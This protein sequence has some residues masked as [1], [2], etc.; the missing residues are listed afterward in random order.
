MG[1]HKTEQP[2]QTHIVGHR[3]RLIFFS[4][5][6]QER[7][8]ARGGCLTRQPPRGP[9]RYNAKFVLVHRYARTLSREGTR[10]SLRASRAP[11]H[12]AQKL[13]N[14]KDTYHVLSTNTRKHFG[15]GKRFKASDGDHTQRTAY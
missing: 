13:T 7:C 1:V 2:S 8:S 3:G 5:L 10:F 15:F 14:L 4:H 6:V 11:R 12:G 9:K